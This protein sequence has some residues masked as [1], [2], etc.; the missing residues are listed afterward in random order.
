MLEHAWNIE[1]TNLEH[2]KLLIYKDILVFWNTFFTIL[3][4]RLCLAMTATL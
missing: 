1:N 4:P 2:V 3:G